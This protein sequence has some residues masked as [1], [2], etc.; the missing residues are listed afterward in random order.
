MHTLSIAAL[1]VLVATESSSAFQ[2][3]S[4]TTTP[5]I[6]TTR[7]R[8][9]DGPFSTPPQATQTTARHSSTIDRNGITSSQDFVAFIP[10]N[11]HVDLSGPV[12]TSTMTSVTAPAPPT[13]SPTPPEFSLLYTPSE[14]F[15]I[16]ADKGK[17][18]AK[19]SNMKT[20]ISAMLGGAYVG[21]G[22][23]LSLAISGN[24]MGIGSANSGIPKLVFA[25]LFPVN[26]LLVLQCGGQLFTGNTAVMTAA[27]CEKKATFKDLARSW[28]LSY[29]ANMFSC[30]LFAV[31]C[32]Y[33]GVLSGGAA[34]LAAQTLLYK[35]SNSFGPTLVKAILCN[36]L[37]CLAVYLS[38]QA[39]D[40]TGKFVGIFL[41][42]ST[43]V[44]IGFEHS[45]ANFF[46]LTAGMLSGS[47]TVGGISLKTIIVSNLIPVTIGNMISGSLLVG[48][49]FSFMYGRLGEGR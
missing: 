2:L 14:A 43:F 32:K 12:T 48:A 46:L 26:L 41:P 23:M 20:I 18:N 40:M 42:V 29:A 47:A 37:V 27:V 49:M 19:M 28:G 16:L 35:T 5:R 8:R 30:V 21:M 33:C 9:Y 25:I 38:S 11:G 10:L 36:W 39:K 4:T 3:K 44:A 45:C 13:P 31:L 34:D 22:G 17:A 1:A 6:L 15:Q 24:M 7:S